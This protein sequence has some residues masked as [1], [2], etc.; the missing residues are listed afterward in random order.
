VLSKWNGKGWV[1]VAKSEG[2]SN[3]ETVAAGG[4]GAYTLTVKVQ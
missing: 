2:P 4:S 3:L 1:Q